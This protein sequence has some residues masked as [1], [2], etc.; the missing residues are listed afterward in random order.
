MPRYTYQCE[1]CEKLFQIAHSI[2]EKYDTCTQCDKECKDKGGL[3]RI[4]SIPLVVSKKKRQ[5][6]GVLVKS[7][8]EET[9]EDL[10]QEKQNLKEEEYKP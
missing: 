1:K 5:P 2:K 9:R 6:V 3:K 8:I 7:F 4:P 10:K